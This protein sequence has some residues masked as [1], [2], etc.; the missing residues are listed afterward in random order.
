MAPVCGKW[1]L[2]AWL[3]EPACHR[4]NRLECVPNYRQFGSAKN[5]EKEERR[6]RKLIKIARYKV[7]KVNLLVSLKNNIKQVKKTTKY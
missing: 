2:E 6:Y 1:T 5:Y 3:V 7:I 4:W